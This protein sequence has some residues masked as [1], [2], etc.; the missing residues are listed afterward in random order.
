MSPTIAVVT[1]PLARRTALLIWPVTLWPAEDSRIWVRSRVGKGPEGHDN[2][3]AGWC[4]RTAKKNEDG[5]GQYLSWLHHEGLLI[6]AD[7]VTDRITPE[8]VATYVLSLKTRLSPEGV[9]AIVGSLTSAARALAPVA[10][11]SWLCRR[12]TRLKL[13]AKPSRDKR[14]AIQHTL[15][16]YRFGQS[17]MDAASRKPRQRRR[18]AWERP[19]SIKR[20]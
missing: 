3:A 10:D 6:E 19:S 13:R 15:D 2:P 16:L 5:Y 4:G 14:H 7:E 18:R 9:A 8:R 12:A 1:D 11:W 17:V 20:D